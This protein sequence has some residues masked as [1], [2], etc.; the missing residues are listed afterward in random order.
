MSNYNKVLGGLLGAAVGDS[1]GAATET[2]SMSQ[3][4]KKFGGYV[5]TF[6]TPPDDVFARGLPAGTVT[7]DFSLA[8]YTAV[9]MIR[10]NGVVDSNCAKSALV[11]WS[12]SKYSSFAGPTTFAAINKLN[13]ISTPSKY[14]FLA[15]DN[16]K[17]SNGGAMKI[18]PVG[19]ISGGNISKA[20][21]DTI[22]ICMPTHD[23]NTSLAGA[24]AVSAA[25][26]EALHD[27]ATVDSVIKAGLMG[28]KAG[29]EYG[30]KYCKE[31]S[32]PSVY[33][34]IELAVKI[35]KASNGNLEKAMVDLCDIIG[36]GLSAAEAVPCAFGILA[37]TNGDPTKCIL[38]G[39]NI[40]NDTD[41]I[42]T[43]VGGIAGTLNSYYNAKQLETINKVNGFTIELVAKKL[44]ELSLAK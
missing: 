36:A 2:R 38:A 11:T 10:N 20:I 23:N 32:N 31:L 42:A 8:Y 12:K 43:I 22:T 39:V 44:L 16:A 3:I 13:G 33:R 1:M 18:V 26:A 27:N 14:D 41:T 4:K 35:G 28:A 5:T 37:A 34:R 6:I 19:L 30:K 15:V 7:D 9:A 40:G 25:V 24:C 21:K 17:G 29:D